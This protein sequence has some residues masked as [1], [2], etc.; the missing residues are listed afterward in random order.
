MLCNDINSIIFKYLNFHDEHKFRRIS[1]SNNKLNISGHCRLPYKYLSK[2]NYIKKLYPDITR[3]I[4]NNVQS[5]NMDFSF[6]VDE[7]H[8][9]ID[10]KKVNKVFD[11]YRHYDF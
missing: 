10:Q 2:M 1:K 9:N 5:Y 11:E 7:I 8:F 6:P 4:F 3:F